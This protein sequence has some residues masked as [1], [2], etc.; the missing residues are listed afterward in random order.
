M[1]DFFTI[2]FFIVHSSHLFFLFE[3]F[4]VD[5]LPKSHFLFIY[6]RFFLDSN[7]LLLVD[8]L[9]FVLI[10][11]FWFHGVLFDL[12]L[13]ELFTSLEVQKSEIVSIEKIDSTLIDEFFLHLQLKRHDSTCLLQ[14]YHLHLFLKFLPRQFVAVDKIF[15][16]IRIFFFMSEY[17]SHCH[18]IFIIIVILRQRVITDLLI[19][20]IFFRWRF[21]CIF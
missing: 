13:N 21:F 19:I 15:F 18:L 6:F 14:T 4:H 5:D 8:V 20:W 2:L 10:C 9:L 16:R 11:H 1:I 17:L 7:L 12:F 3:C